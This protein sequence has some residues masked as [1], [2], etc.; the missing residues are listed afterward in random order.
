MKLIITNYENV[1]RVKGNLIKLNIPIFKNELKDVFN[2]ADDVILNLQ[3]LNAIDNQGVVA[4]A[5]LHNE[6]LSKNKK[7]SI[8]GL[9]N[10][11][12]SSRL[13]SNQVA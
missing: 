6:A 5:Q 7:L 8:I 11:Q 9:D 10:G 12:V 4:I 1:Y 13:K 3:E 2:Q